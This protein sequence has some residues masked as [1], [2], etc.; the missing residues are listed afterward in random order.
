MQITK[1]KT[2]EESIENW[3]KRQAQIIEIQNRVK[4]MKDN[5]V[6]E[7]QTEKQK[8]EEEKKKEAA[9]AYEDWLKKKGPVK[10]PE[11]KVKERRILT[12]SKSRLIIGPYS[13]A[14]SLKDMQRKINMYND[15][16]SEIKRTYSAEEMQNENKIEDSLQELSSI[17]RDTAEHDD[18]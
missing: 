11:P 12:S 16:S 2:K 7:E 18:Y 3:I 9:Q 10:K 17:K 14:K 8:K 5:A 4:K 6:K 13:T 15:Q 1:Q